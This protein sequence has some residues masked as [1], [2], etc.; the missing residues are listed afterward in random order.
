MGMSRQIKRQIERKAYIYRETFPTR[1]DKAIRAQSIR[2]R[3]AM[4]GLYMAKDAPWRSDLI[5]EMMAFPVAVHDDQVDAL[6]L[7]GQLLDRMETGEPIRKPDVKPK[8]LP[9]QV[10][11]PGEPEPETSKRI[12]I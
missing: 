9:G 1:G 6:G 11:L 3:I 7:V 12:K 2:G 4:R 5:A 10:L 8:A